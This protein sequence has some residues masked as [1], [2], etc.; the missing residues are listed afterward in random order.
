MQ[1]SLKVPNN[2]HERLH[3]AIFFFWVCFFNA[4]TSVL[5]QYFGTNSSV[6]VPRTYLC[7]VMR[8]LF[9]S[10]LSQVTA[11]GCAQT[12]EPLINALTDTDVEKPKKKKKA[13]K[14]K[15]ATS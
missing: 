14:G 6:Q 2:T 10:A 9:L 15:T 5:M 12:M 11:T 4:N 8:S 7:S 3:T 13:K 1:N